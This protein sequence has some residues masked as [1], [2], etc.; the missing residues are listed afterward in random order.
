MPP[1]IQYHAITNGYPNVKPGTIE[2]KRS[3]IDQN[4][5]GKWLADTTGATTAA[6]GPVGHR[7]V[8]APAQ[9]DAALALETSRDGHEVAVG[10]RTI[11]LQ[12][13]TDASRRSR[14]QPTGS[15]HRVDGAAGLAWIWCRSH[16]RDVRGHAR[17]AGIRSISP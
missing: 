10:G 1:V 14:R 7:I 15:H 12:P 3:H 8:G 2:T 13:Q 9:G 17:A 4:F 5:A 16:Q 11:A 6:V